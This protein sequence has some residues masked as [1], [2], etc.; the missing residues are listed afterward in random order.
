MKKQTIKEAFNDANIADTRQWLLE[1]GLRSLH[2]AFAECDTGNRARIVEEF[3]F[4][5]QA[6]KFY[7]EH[8]NAC[9]TFE[10]DNIEMPTERERLS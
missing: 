1:D 6:A 4:I 10:H 5:A 8:S 3:P 7:G 2:R 9:N